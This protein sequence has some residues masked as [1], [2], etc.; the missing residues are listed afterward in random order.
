MKIYQKLDSTESE[1]KLIEAVNS[2]DSH[3]NLLSRQHA[4]DLSKINKLEIRIKTL[5]KWKQ[6]QL[7]K[8][9]HEY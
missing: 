8:Q 6:Q 3:V 4:E 9:S 5:E 7:L 1:K 2:L